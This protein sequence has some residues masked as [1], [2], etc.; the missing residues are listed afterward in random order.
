MIACA[1]LKTERIRE[2]QG[3]P[4]AGTAAVTGE[5]D[6]PEAPPDGFSKADGKVPLLGAEEARERMRRQIAAN[7][8]AVATKLTGAGR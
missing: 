2:A 6:K 3:L 8:R 4:P 1:Q 5:R 7:V